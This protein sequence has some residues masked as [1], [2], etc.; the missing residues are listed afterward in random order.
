MMPLRSSLGD[1]MHPS[2]EVLERSWRTLSSQRF[3]QLANPL[4]QH[5]NS[6]EVL[7]DRLF[8]ADRMLRG[9]VDNDQLAILSA[10][11]RAV[12][13]TGAAEVQ[14]STGTVIESAG[15]VSDEVIAHALRDKIVDESDTRS[16]LGY[17]FSQNEQHG[18]YLIITLSPKLGQVSILFLAAPAARFSAVGEPIAVIIRSAWNVLTTSDSAEAE[19]TVLSALRSQF[20]RLPLQLY[21]RG[22]D[23]YSRL[24]ES[25]VMVFEPV[26]TISHE[27]RVIGIHSW[28]AL[29]RRDGHAHRAPVNIL[30]TADNWGDRF[31]IERDSALAVKAIKSY[32]SAH[33]EGPWS[34]D[35]P[36]PVS[37][38]VS[39]RALLSDAYSNYLASAISEVGLAA[40]TVTLEIS[41]QDPI[42]P[43][44]DEVERW[45]PDPIAYFKSRMRN[46]SSKL[47]VDFAIDDFG[48]GHASLD[49]VA[50]L[51]LTQIKVDRAI[52]HHSMAL[53]EIELVVQ[54]ANEALSRG[55]SAASRP[56]IVEGFDSE[57]PVSLRD[58]Y[59]LGI[60]Y[61][62]GHITED[63]ATTELHALSGEVRRKVA[64]MVQGRL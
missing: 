6:I 38:N 62:Q 16:V 64:L 13:A 28:E 48:V 25:L 47:H 34:N 53:K 14:L 55:S 4:E 50:S 52:L 54:L 60:G 22:L 39:V 10:I 30:T 18:R 11:M 33:E 61:V 26:M 37:I 3:E 35:T 31:L 44:R 56:V 15:M 12:E 43:N 49:R 36:K 40:H 59:S 7:L 23:I 42:E 8:R 63:P 51:D 46:L 19:I 2:A 1:T 20:G 21:L 17:T 24:L 45:K 57:C 29:A 41:E 5:V 27:P 32:A 58:L 9:T